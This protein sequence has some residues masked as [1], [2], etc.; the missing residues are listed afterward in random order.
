MVLDTIPT[1]PVSLF[2][3]GYETGVYHKE[4]YM[5]FIPSEAEGFE[6]HNFSFLYYSKRS[7]QRR[8]R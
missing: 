2:T 4:V 6:S 7:Y 5:G 8:W 1:V 3:L